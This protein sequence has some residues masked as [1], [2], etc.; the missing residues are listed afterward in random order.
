MPL[1]LIINCQKSVIALSLWWKD[2]GF[3]IETDSEAP[4]VPLGKRNLFQSEMGITGFLI[5]IPQVTVASLLGTQFTLANFSSDSF[6]LSSSKKQGCRFFLLFLTKRKQDAFGHQKQSFQRRQFRM[7]WKA[8]ACRLK[9]QLFP[10][11]PVS[12]IP[13]TAALK[14]G[15]GLVCK[16]N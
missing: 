11:L 5:K 2:R 1:G 4:G 7:W 3:T 16:I 9:P 15:W 8:N 12:G 6:V 10:P 14:V 13:E